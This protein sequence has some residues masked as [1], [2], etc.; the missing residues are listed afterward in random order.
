MLG[1]G[2]SRRDFLRS[3]GSTL[4]LWGVT[5]NSALCSPSSEGVLVVVFQ[6][7]AADALHMVVPYREKRYRELRGNLALEEPSRGEASTLDLGDGFAFH[8]A[9]KPL[10]S[11]YEA[12][13]LAVLMNVGSPDSTRSHFDAQDYMESGTPGKKSTR[14]GWLARAIGAMNTKSEGAFTAVALAAQMPRSLAGA[15][16]AVAL[17]DFSKLD[18]HSGTDPLVSAIEEQYGKDRSKKLAD[19]SHEG[20]EA[21]RLFREKA[22]LSIP[23]REG[24]HY[25][26]GRGGN[27]L[28]QLAQL[29]KGE[30]GIR[31]AL[32]NSDGWDTHFGQGGSTGQMANLLNNLSGGLAAFVEDVGSSV[33]LT[34]LVVTEFGR[35]VAINGAGGTDHGHGGAMF[36][37][38]GRVQS[39]RVYGDWLGLDKK[40]LHDGRDLPVTTDYR[41]VFYEVAETALEVN[42]A[43]D[44]FPGH[45]VSPI[46][47]MKKS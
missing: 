39:S 30:L 3:S 2:T 37:L 10:Y 13:R 23:T 20:F 38:G 21:M 4:L 42:S 36:V 22:P 11:H 27:P 19:A 25:P 32:V 17:E 43:V 31:V 1:K 18:F 24:V 47:V 33:P 6:R 15:D 46:N 5:P 29:I 12:G 7:G 44:L 14:S 8:P 28:R 45:L 35:T 16:D 26:R 9:L 40:H 34:V 41:D